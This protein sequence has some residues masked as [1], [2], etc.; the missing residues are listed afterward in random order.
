MSSRDT[1][2]P[3]YFPSTYA[4]LGCAPH[5][6]H[7][8]HTFPRFVPTNSDAPVFPPILSGP[9]CA[10]FKVGLLP[11]SFWPLTLQ[12]NSTS[13][14]LPHILLPLPWCVCYFPPFPP[15]LSPYEFPSARTSPL[16]SCSARAL[17]K[18]DV[19]LPCFPPA[20]PSVV[21]LFPPHFPQTSPLLCPYVFPSARTSPLLSGPGGAPFKV[22]LLS[23]TPPI[24]W[25][26][27]GAPLLAFPHTSPV[28]CP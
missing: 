14:L 19:L 26:F 12:G 22:A 9:G 18:V 7:P 23:L 2:S 24:L 3:L 8:A 11:H 16:L 1:T 21:C 27:R 4:P 17:F 28:L 20:L 25:P 13:P 10:P 15:L 5:P 6:L